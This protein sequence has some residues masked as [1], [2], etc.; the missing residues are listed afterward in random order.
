[1]VS[2]CDMF[3][4]YGRVTNRVSLDTESATR[5]TFFYFLLWHL[6]NKSV[7]LNINGTVQT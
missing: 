4:V 1:M 6:A 5:Y 7:I 2:I 3:Y